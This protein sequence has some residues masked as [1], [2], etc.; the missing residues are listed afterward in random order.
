M[1]TVA[2]P[3]EREALVVDVRW[4]LPGG[5]VSLYVLCA[6]S[7]GRVTG[8]TRAVYVEN[9]RLEGDGVVLRKEALHDRTTF[10]EQVQ[11]VFDLLPPDVTRLE[12]ILSASRSGVVL[13]HLTGIEIDAW[14]PKDGVSVRTWNPTD[15]GLAKRLEMLVL[16]KVS[17]GWELSAQRRV[18]EFDF[19]A[20]FSER[21]SQPR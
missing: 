18:S 19:A 9:P 1:S 20:L 16:E 11:V 14:D 3:P 8:P 10:K 2:L 7:Q 15:P 6:D 17:G 12:L 21:Y 13:T 4:T 5:G